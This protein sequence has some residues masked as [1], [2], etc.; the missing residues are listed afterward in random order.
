MNEISVGNTDKLGGSA[1]GVEALL[2]Q[3]IATAPDG[4]I[5]WAD[6]VHTSLYS[7][8]GYYSSGHASIGNQHDADFKTAP[9]QHPVFSHVVGNALNVLWERQEKPAFFPLIESGAGNGTMGHDILDKLQADFP[10]LY[11]AAHYVTVEISPELAKKQQAH[12]EDHGNKTTH[13]NASTID[14]P[15]AHVRGGVF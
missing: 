12:M 14:L 11:E 6:F 15:L 4:H 13:V 3:Q 2:R 7:E 8:N 5:T 9:E 10:A 1:P